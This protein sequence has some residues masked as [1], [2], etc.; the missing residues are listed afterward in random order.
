MSHGGPWVL[1]SSFLEMKKR[2]WGIK[3]HTIYHVSPEGCGQSGLP[4]TTS[5]LLIS[6]LSSFLKL[7]YWRYLG[8]KMESIFWWATLKNKPSVP[9]P[10]YFRGLEVQRHV[11]GFISF[12]DEE[13]DFSYRP[14]VSSHFLSNKKLLLFH[15]AF[16]CFP[17]KMIE[18]SNDNLNSSLLP[19]YITVKVKRGQAAGGL[20]SPVLS[21]HRSG[22]DQGLACLSFC[23]GKNLPDF[24]TPPKP[25][26]PC[27]VAW[28]PIYI[29]G[30]WWLERVC[31]F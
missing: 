17:P 29:L 3:M 6:L 30:L 24:F 19:E 26:S 21:I 22:G 25:L 13:V 27:N 20:R 2:E 5:D 7:H 15:W 4:Q 11:V 8:I 10:Q 16:H 28:S 14:G 1:E 9:L 12:L 18:A 23:G 31:I